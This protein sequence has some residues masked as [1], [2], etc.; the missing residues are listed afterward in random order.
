MCGQII[1][2]N[3]SLG[4]DPRP[5]RLGDRPPPRLTRGLTPILSRSCAG[6]TIASHGGRG[7]RI[8]SLQMRCTC[9][10]PRPNFGSY[11]KKSPNWIIVQIGDGFGN[12]QKTIDRL[13]KK[14]PP[15]GSQSLENSIITPGRYTKQPCFCGSK[16]PL[17]T[18]A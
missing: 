9:S 16:L 7:P 2:W 1:C 13:E 3:Y 6:A 5:D 10:P 8:S 4:S 15:H 11:A 14:R 18:S 17:P 12:V